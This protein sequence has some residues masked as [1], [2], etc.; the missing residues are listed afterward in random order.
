MSTHVVLVDGQLAAGS[1][2]VGRTSSLG[3][4]SLGAGE[5]EGLGQDDGT[6]RAVREVGN[7][8]SVGL[9]V[10]GGGRAT[11]SNSLG[12]TLSGAGDTSG[13]NGVGEGGQRRENDGR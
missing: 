8:L 1:G 10:D 9:G 13:S 6:G 4:G 7:K 11:A 5:V 12:E 3:R 2:A